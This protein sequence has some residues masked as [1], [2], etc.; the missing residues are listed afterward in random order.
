MADT[1]LVT[2]FPN[3]TAKRLVRRLLETDPEER[4]FLLARDKFRAAATDYLSTLP[5]DARARVEVVVGDVCDIDLGLTGAE[6]TALAGTITAIHHTA[7]IY[8]LGAKRRLVE[9]VNVDGTREVL[10]LAQACTRLRRFTHWSTAQVS[11][12][13]SGVILEEE[14]DTGQ[15]FH[16]VYEET[17]FRAE[18]MVREAARALPITVVRPGVIVGDSRTGEIDRFDGPYYLIVLIVSSPLDVSL[19]L[20]G[21][22]NAPLNLVPIDFVVDAATVLSRDPRA[23]GGTFHL[24]DPC[25]FSARTVYELVAERADRKA[26]R[27]VIPTGL[28][29]SFLRAPGLER[30]TRAPLAFLEAFNHLA[31]YNCRHALALLDDAGVHCPP[32]DSYVD[33]LV[34]FVKEAQA[35]RQRAGELDERVGHDALD[36]YDDADAGRDDERDRTPEGRA[37][38]V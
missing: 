10:D 31:V 9:S 38:R 2:G 16:N 3:F 11:G 12:T 6:Y 17:K 24:T 26:P 25:P 20:P 29:R 15:R 1:T 33:A 21:R 7:A 27:G 4:V 35:R 5:D 18:R 22:G 36:P 13:R 32:F 8:F 14:L 28:L 37:S 30:L 34:R 23:A 19:P